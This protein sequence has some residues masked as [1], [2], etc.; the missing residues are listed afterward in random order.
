[1]KIGASLRCENN[2]AIT[3]FKGRSG[4]AV[5]DF[6][7]TMF[8]EKGVDLRGLIFH[9]NK[10]EEYEVLA[11]LGILSTSGAPSR[12]VRKLSRKVQNF[13]EGPKEHKLKKKADVCALASLD[14]ELAFNLL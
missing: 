13:S 7:G 6:K 14:S 2:A 11:E 12:R 1:M 4:Y 8:A 5:K 3:I 10:N 9:H